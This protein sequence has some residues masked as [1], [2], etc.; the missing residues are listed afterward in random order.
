MGD[1][2]T[3]NRS[4]AFVPHLSSFLHGVSHVL[5][6]CRLIAAEVRSYSARVQAMCIW[7]PLCQCSPSFGQTLPEVDQLHPKLGKVGPIWARVWLNSVKPG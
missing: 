4:C 5:L 1:P 6:T 3:P 2:G 7:P